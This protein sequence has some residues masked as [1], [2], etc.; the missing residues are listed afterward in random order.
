MNASPGP[1]WNGSPSYREVMARLNLLVDKVDWIA[2][3]VS[4]IEQTSS[5][6]MGRLPGSEETADRPSR[7]PQGQQGPPTARPAPSPA[8]A[9]ARASAS[10]PAAGRTPTGE[11]DA[12]GAGRS[13]GRA[14]AGGPVTDEEGRRERAEAEGLA[15]AEEVAEAVFEEAPARVADSP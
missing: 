3:R 15:I 7:T 14:S 12:A 5:S 4:T 1:S 6:L 10:P 2:A 8:A 11:K 13:A 9:G